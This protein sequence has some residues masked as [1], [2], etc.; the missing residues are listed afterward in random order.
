MKKYYFILIAIFIFNNDINATN[1]TVQT[2]GM[3]FSPSSITINSGDS[4][5]FVNT[6]GWH[7]V[8]GTIQTFPANPESFSNPSGISSGWTYVHVFTIAGT[9]NYQCDPHLPGMVG[10]IIVKHNRL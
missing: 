5:T 8:N 3:T 9:Y 1:H 7:N 6:S 4:V 10:S 2:L